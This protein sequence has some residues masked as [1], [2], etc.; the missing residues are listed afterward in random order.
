MCRRVHDN[1]IVY[2]ADIWA[3]LRIP[4]PNYNS[5]VFRLL[6]TNT[7]CLT[8]ITRQD[9]KNNSKTFTEHVY[10]EE[11]W[12]KCTETQRTLDVVIGAQQFQVIAENVSLVAVSPLERC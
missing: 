1:I 4:V 2:L 3:L 5:T 12:Y 6:V 9:N 10:L 7:Y 11:K 8:K